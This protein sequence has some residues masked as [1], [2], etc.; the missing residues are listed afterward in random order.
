MRQAKIA[1]FFPSRSCQATW[2]RSRGSAQMFVDFPWGSDM[3]QALLSVDAAF[4]QGDGPCDLAAVVGVHAF[5]GTWWTVA[6]EVPAATGNHHPS[7]APY[8]LFHTGTSAVQLSVGSERQWPRFCRAVGLPALADEP[9]F[10]MDVPARGRFRLRRP[11]APP[12]ACGRG[13][14]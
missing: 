1:C 4:A 9:R 2:W 8:G 3:R 11:L 7:V 13:A 6:G 14:P 12:P 5:Q 10:E